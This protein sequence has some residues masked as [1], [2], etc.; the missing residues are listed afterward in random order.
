[1]ETMIAT[2]RDFVGALSLLCLLAASFGGLT[3]CLLSPKHAQTVLGLLFGI[4]AW[5]QMQMPLT[6]FDGV[7]ID[8]RNVPVV[9]AGAFLGIRG[10]ICCL[11]IAAGARIGIGGIGWPSGVA[12]MLIAGIVG[13]AWSEITRHVNRRIWHILALS[14]VANLHLV[15]AFML[16]WHIAVWFYVNA[17]PVVMCLNLIG[18]TIVGLLLQRER[19]RIAQDAAL[20]NAARNEPS[21]GLLLPAPFV[22]ELRHIRASADG[23]APCAIAVATLRHPGWIDA[24]WGNEALA[25]IQGA[26][27]KRIQPLV[28]HG[29]VLGLDGRKRLLIPLT[30]RE[31]AGGLDITH[32]ARAMADDPVEL[33]DNTKVR[34]TVEVSIA[35]MTSTPRDTGELNQILTRAYRARPDAVRAKP[36]PSHPVSVVCNPQLESIAPLQRRLFA[37]VDLVM[38]TQMG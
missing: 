27:R 31:L 17:A 35:P 6:P 16:P 33:D 10:L 34:A 2:M 4:C 32:L 29:D 15:A 26:L 28:A 3:R 20:Q 38:R 1:M 18:I 9:L 22:T 19:L 12:G 25:V 11:L 14:A 36:K 8:M 23:E 24:L 21:S 13:F 30:P 7:I 37:Q 5:I